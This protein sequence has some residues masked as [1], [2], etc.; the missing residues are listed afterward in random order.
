MK[1]ENIFSLDNEAFRY[2]VLAKNSDNSSD[3]L[4]MNETV[5]FSQSWKISSQESGRLIKYASNLEPLLIKEVVNYNQT[6]TMEHSFIQKIL[7][8][9]EAIE[10]N[11]SSLEGT[12]KQIIDLL[13]KI[14]CFLVE[15]AV[16]VFNDEFDGLLEE[17]INEKKSSQI[18]TDMQV[19]KYLEACRAQYA[20]RIKDFQKSKQFEDAEVEDAKAQLEKILKRH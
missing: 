13:A 8:A 10:R 17:R 3:Y 20:S 16:T 11:K 12:Q 1:P 7:D 6:R 19:A 9:F 5:S 18:E 15:R 4:E 14:T 2:L